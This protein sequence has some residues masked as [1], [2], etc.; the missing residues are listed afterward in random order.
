MKVLGRIVDDRGIRMDPDKVDSI[1]NWKV[2][3][4]K[5]LL[6]GFLG[7]VGYLADD[8]ATVRI[9]MGTLASMTGANASFKWDFTHQRAFDEIKQLVHAHREHHRVPLDYS[10]NAPPVWLVTDGSHGGIAGVVSQG[11][12]FRR[13]RVA[14]FFSAKL[15]STQQNYP[16]HEIEMLAGIEAMLRHRDI[17]LGCPFTWVTDH[18]GLIHL[19]NQ[20]NLSGRQARWMEKIAEY[21][22]KIEYVPGVENVLAD[23][24]SR[25]YSNDQPGTVRAPS[26]YTQHDDGA[27]APVSLSAHAVSVP[28]LV[29]VEGRA[30]S[31]LTSGSSAVAPHRSERLRHAAARPRSPLVLSM[32]GSRLE[33]ASSASHRRA[34]PRTRGRVIASSRPPQPSSKAR[35]SSPI[36]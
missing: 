28:V 31:E 14:A 26:E 29:D 2:P 3:I 10:E 17:L 5:E 25:I 9:P 11:D 20:R 6:R 23:A 8:I 13:A 4:S 33:G 27:A 30:A 32:V 1:M 34:L 19:L 36:A 7:S 15:S 21:D 24:L 18:K 35:S 22:F 12:D 16:V